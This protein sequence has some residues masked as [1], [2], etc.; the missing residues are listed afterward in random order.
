MASCL[1]TVVCV[2]ELV[3]VYST[4]ACLCTA[5]VCL[6]AGES[7]KITVVPL[8]LNL[9]VIWSHVEWNDLRSSCHLESLTIWQREKE[10]LLIRI[11]THATASMQCIRDSSPKNSNHVDQN[12]YEHC[13]AQNKK[14]WRTLV[15]KLLWTP[16]T[17]N[18]KTKR[19]FSK[20]HLSCSTRSK[21][22]MFSFCVNY[23]F[24]SLIFLSF[25]FL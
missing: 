17:F 21:R 23:S 22:H 4:F 1:L 2:C 10:A 6:C 9:N 13:G 8:W 24:N 20:Y 19:H 3:F 12:L 5:C 14:F 25:L 18:I 15:S 11:Q 16:L 7:H